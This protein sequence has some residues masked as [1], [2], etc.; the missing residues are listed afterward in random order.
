MECGSV[1]ASYDERVIDILRFP[2]A[3]TRGEQIDL[4]EVPAA[5]ETPDCFVWV[6]LLNA[7]PDE[8]EQIEAMFD[9]PMDI[10]EH[11]GQREHRVKLVRSGDVFHVTIRDAVLIDDRISVNDVDVVLG[12]GWILTQLDH[13]TEDCISFETIRTRFAS[14]GNTLRV[15]GIGTIF[16]ALLDV[17]VDRYFSVTDEIDNRIDAIEEIVFGGDR[18]FGIP[19]ESY[20]LRR[21]LV[22]FRRGSVP[23]REVIG[24]VLR[25]EVSVVEPETVPL[26]QDVQDHVLRIGDLVESQREVLTGLLE[27]HLAIVSN[28][29][30][31]VMKATSSWGAILL[32]S[33]LI[34]GIY[35]MNFRHMPELSMTF[36]YPAALGAMALATFV[37]YRLFKK[38][39]W[40]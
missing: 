30:N 36:G 39:D 16:W 15:A 18:Q 40:L 34:A 12:R 2:S 37:L 27:A 31:Q 4:T 13:P 22:R 6:R 35:G 29:M 9:L 20:Q 5:L 25:H 28:S 7:T 17:T 19:Q 10:V 11:L 33:T 14:E 1:V 24:A 23:L 26:F 21:S 38:R 8:L 32:V 3:P